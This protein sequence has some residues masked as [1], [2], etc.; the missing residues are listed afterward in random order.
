MATH[1]L[2]LLICSRPKEKGEGL[3]MVD[4]AN[5][6][7]SMEMDRERMFFL[8]LNEDYSLQMDYDDE[9]LKYISE[10]MSKTI[11]L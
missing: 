1:L 7:R 6:M 3:E 5:K 9:T 11:K 2:G 10:N 4:M 8:E